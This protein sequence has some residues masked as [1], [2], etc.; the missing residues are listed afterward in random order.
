MI[1]PN[2][3]DLALPDFKLI[4]KRREKHV[5]DFPGKAWSVKELCE[6]GDEADRLHPTP[7]RGRFG[8]YW[9]Y[10]IEENY[11]CCDAS[12]SHYD[13]EL[14]RVDLDMF[15]MHLAEKS[16]VTPEIVGDLIYLLKE[17]FGKY[18]WSPVTVKKQG[19]SRG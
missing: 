2:T 14:D 11:I 3:A 4:L 10:D 6:V 13:I 16:W 5:G 7:P 15:P 9:H 12:G 18:D 19:S 17:V 8:L 1:R